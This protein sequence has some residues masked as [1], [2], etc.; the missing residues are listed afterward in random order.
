MKEPIE[1]AL[2]K[3]KPAPMPPALMARLTAARP[4]A[5]E[6]RP[7]W[8]RWLLPFATAACAAFGAM[9][10][11]SS[12]DASKPK[13]I[14]AATEPLPFARNDYLVGTREI[15]MFIAPDQRPYRVMEIEWLEQDT[16]ASS[17]AGPTILMETKRRE[18]VPV[19]LEIF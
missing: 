12:D 1:E 17:L 15:G 18:V 19:A 16:I 10:Y 4:Q 9:H 6:Q 13:R 2:E 14:I 11:L 3:M 8:T 5:R 7:W